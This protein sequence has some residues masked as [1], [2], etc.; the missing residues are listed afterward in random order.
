MIARTP[1]LFILLI[2]IPYLYID[3]GF[4]RRRFA[5][6]QRIVW[7][8]PTV[9]ML[10]YT[11]LLWMER[12]FIPDNPDVLFVY[13]LLLGVLVIPKWTFSICSALGKLCCRLLHR[14]SNYGNLLGLL[15]VPLVLYVVIYGAFVG[16]GKLEVRHIDYVSPDLPE[17]FDGY[18]IV[19]FS[20]AHVGTLTGIRSH[21]LQR[22]IDS[23][24]AQQPD[25]IV[26]TGDLQN[27]CPQEVQ[28]H[29]QLLSTLRAKDGVFSVLG[30]HDYAEYV[31]C[32]EQQKAAN[33]RELARLEQQLGWTLLCNEHRTIRRDT[34]RII[35][36]GMEND[37][38]GKRFPRKGDIPKTLK[39]VAD[40]D[41]IIMLEHDPYSW[42]HR[43]LPESHAQ[44]TLSGHVHA[45]QFKLGNWSPISLHVPEWYGLY[46][47]DS[48]T[49]FVTAGMSGLIPF[50]FGVAGEIAVI[51]LHKGK[52]SN[53]SIKNP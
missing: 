14:R 11:L 9:A 29:R 6:W 40:D 7:W 52:T 39:G 3:W 5:P 33:C 2:V 13:L 18:R 51:T 23:I 50:R 1:Y 32:D 21:I 19:H 15:T 4:I 30:N 49:L 25:M 34:A 35:I 48:Q 53:A 24:N 38:N 31:N 28:Q 41:F 10:V 8:L 26:F 47:E 22:D 12:N 46:R 20:D 42:R 17:A 27:A 16:F 36:A 43:I 45:M 44:L 37:G